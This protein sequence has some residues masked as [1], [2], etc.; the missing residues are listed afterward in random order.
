LKQA[1]PNLL[2]AMKKQSFL[3]YYLNITF[4][5]C[6]I[7][8]SCKKSGE[9]PTNTPPDT[10]PVVTPAVTV[11]SIQPNK[12]FAGDTVN[13]T[14]TN[15]STLSSENKVSFYG[16]DAT[17]IATSST[18]LTVIVP[19]NSTTGIIGIK[20]KNADFKF[21]PVFTY[22]SPVN[23]SGLSPTETIVGKTV[24]IAGANFSTVP[25]ENIVMFNGKQ[26]IVK[27][28]TETQLTADVPQGATTGSIKVTVMKHTTSSQV[29]KVVTIPKSLIWSEIKA[30]DGMNEAVMAASIDSIMVFINTIGGNYHLFKSVNGQINDVYANL[31]NG[32]GFPYQIRSSSSAFYLCT[33]TGLFK[34][35]DGSIWIKMFPIQPTIPGVFNDII[36]TGEYLKVFDGDYSYTS[37]NE[38]MTWN[39]A[40][41]F[42]SENIYGAGSTYGLY[43]VRDETSKYYYCV[44]NTGAVYTST[45]Q[46]QNWIHAK[47]ITGTYYTSQ[48][49]RDFL[50]TSGDNVFCVFAPNGGYYTPI[51]KRLYKSTDHGDS[52]T[53]V[54]DD[55]INV[56]EV[57]GDY[58]MY[59]YDS[60][61]LSI[62]NG[63]TFTKFSIPAGYIIGGIEKN[64]GYIYIFCKNSSSTEN[65]IFRTPI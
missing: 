64:G 22:A 15:F 52:W 54:S 13:I 29:F 39:Y 28:A 53:K 34:S 37:T 51:D 31:P 3:I 57:A 5:L 4:L 47:G 16:T 6:V 65:K 59:G 19:S 24:T 18:K 7:L 25:S 26:A 60:F 21:G 14:G 35:T 10:N 46:G 12:G 58:L 23:I 62:D 2:I 30:P 38:G 8:N 55:Y 36:V 33:S 63:N 48:G 43:Y 11:E 20:V 32:G 27:T 40:P 49:Y 17:I 1:R 50:K 41:T 56:I 9:T 45:N 61:N 42:I 44:Y